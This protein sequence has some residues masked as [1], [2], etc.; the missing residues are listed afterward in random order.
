MTRFIESISTHQLLPPYHSEGAKV[1]GFLF[2]IAT[3][4]IQTY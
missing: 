1:N 3:T 4:A 2:E